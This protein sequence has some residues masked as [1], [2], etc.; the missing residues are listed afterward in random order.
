M[1]IQLARGERQALD[2]IPHDEVGYESPSKHEDEQCSLCEH[3]IP[4]MVPRCQAV[5]NPIKPA[6]WCKRYARKE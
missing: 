6:D 3:Y 5:K 4:A 2:K 1:L